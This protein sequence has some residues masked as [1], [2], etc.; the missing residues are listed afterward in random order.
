M[1]EQQ[2]QP[3]Q[4]STSGAKKLL[5]YHII[6]REGMRKPVW[7]RIGAAFVNRDGS[8]NV[9]LDVPAPKPE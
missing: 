4:T 2:T 6:E 3:P 1:N 9:R 8:L 7:L 5:V